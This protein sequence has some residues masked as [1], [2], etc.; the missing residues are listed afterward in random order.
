M[1]DGPLILI[2]DDNE[3]ARYSKARILRRVGFEVVEA[4]D[5][6]EALHL[7]AER[8]PRLLILD[9]QMPGIDGWEVCRRLRADAAN[10]SLLIL[11]VS[12]TYVREE[13]TVR[14]LEGG[15]DAC[16]TE[17]IEAPVLIATV[18]AL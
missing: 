9:V 14:A 17:P 5:G 4:V 10:A 6:T 3:T 7:V 1:A 8:K 2:A 11:Q 13:D 12:A 15:A 18:R 16:L